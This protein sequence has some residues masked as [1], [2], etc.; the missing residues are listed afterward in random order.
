[1]FHIKKL[2]KN[3]NVIK[4]WKQTNKFRIISQRWLSENFHFEYSLRE[5]YSREQFLTN[6]SLVIVFAPFE[7]VLNRHWSKNESW[8]VNER[9]RIVFYFRHL[10][11]ILLGTILECIH[12]T[13]MIHRPSKGSTKVLVEETTE[14]TGVL[15]CNRRTVTR[16]HRESLTERGREDSDSGTTWFS[17]QRGHSM[18]ERTNERTYYTIR[19][20]LAVVGRR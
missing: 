3:C 11:K 15:V 6:F 13:E 19:K 4:L 8:T 7:Q 16:L 18:N 2:N 14:S 20:M 12:D 1:M 5:K 9:T 17:R 10:L